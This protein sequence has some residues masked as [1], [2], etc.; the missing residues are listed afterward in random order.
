[1]TLIRIRGQLPTLNSTGNRCPRPVIKRCRA[2]EQVSKSLLHAA[3]R[4][5]RRRRVCALSQYA[6]RAEDLHVPRWPLRA[7]R[8]SYRAGVQRAQ[9]DANS[10]RTCRSR[11]ST[12]EER[13]GKKIT[14]QG[15]TSTDAGGVASSFP[16]RINHGRPGHSAPRIDS[17]L[18]GGAGVEDADK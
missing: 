17:L 15:A 18:P 6:R 4:R 1:M 10:R 11:A 16:T 3:R 5:R 12:P 2:S 13:R 14:S 9:H 7:P 8:L